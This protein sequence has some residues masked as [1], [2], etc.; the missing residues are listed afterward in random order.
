VFGFVAFTLLVV[1]I[2]QFVYWRQRLNKAGVY[3]QIDEDAHNPYT[4]Q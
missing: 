1:N 2:V 4:T 3:S